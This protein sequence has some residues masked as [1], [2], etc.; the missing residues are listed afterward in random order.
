MSM[1]I[2]YPIKQQPEW[3]GPER[4]AVL[5]LIWKFTHADFK[6]HAGSTWGPEYVGKQTIVV[7]HRGASALCLL[8][9]LSSDQINSRL[10][11]INFR[12]AARR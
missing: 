2:G 10:R 4:E 6:G 1:K 8:E 5:K 3:E 12:L 7:S 9:E 11:Y